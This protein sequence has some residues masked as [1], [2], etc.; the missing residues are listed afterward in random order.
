MLD[1]DVDTI[2][3]LAEA[4]GDLHA[5]RHAAGVL[6]LDDALGRMRPLDRLPADGNRA[7]AGTHRESALAPKIRQAADVAVVRQPLWPTLDVRGERK[8][9]LERRLHLDAKRASHGRSI[10]I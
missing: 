2:V 10:A 9:P 5:A 4:P 3:A 6:E 1:G 8:D 7:A